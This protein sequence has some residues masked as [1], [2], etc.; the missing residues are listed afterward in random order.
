MANDPELRNKT[1]DGIPEFLA[2]ITRAWAQSSS[3]LVP[4]LAV[5]SA[6]LMGVP[7]LIISAGEGSVTEG[8][9]VS[10]DAYSALIEGAT[11]IAINNAMSA[12]SFDVLEDYAETTEIEAARF[13]P[14]AD[15]FARVAEIGEENLDRYE[16]FL[17]DYPILAEY[18]D[19]TFTDTT[20]RLD[21]LRDEFDDPDRLRDAADTLALLINTEASNG[22]VEGLAELVTDQGAD[23]DRLGTI[24]A[25]AERIP[26]EDI[27]DNIIDWVESNPFGIYGGDTVDSLLLLDDTTIDPAFWQTFAEMDDATFNQTRDDLSVVQELGFVATQRYAGVL[28]TLDELGIELRSNDADTIDDINELGLST[29]QEAIATSNELIEKGIDDPEALNAQLRRVGNFYDAGYLQSE[30]VNQ[31]LAEELA[32]ALDEHL[33]IKR[34]GNLFPLLI[35]D[36]AG[37]NIIGQVDNNQDLPVL[38]F[39]AGNVVFMFI[40]SELENT[41]VRAIP[42]IIAGLAVA[43][44]F[45]AGL[46]NIGAEGQIYMGALLVAWLGVALNLPAI[47]HL[48]VI[49]IVGIIGGFLYGAIPGALKAY[50]GAHEVITTIML[51]F[52]AI[53]F[54]DWIIKTDSSLGIGD[55]D[56]SLPRTRTIDVS[57]QMPTFDQL[58]PFLI[59]SVGFALFALLYWLRRNQPNAIMTPLL[60]GISIIIG[61]FVLQVLAVQ[62][63]LHLGFVLMLLAVWFTDWFLDR[64]TAGFEIRT[65][66]TNAN[67]ARYAGM[68]VNWNI[69]L[70]MALSGALAG[71]A[72]MIEI[73]AKEL[74]MQP[75]FIA[76][77]GFD[78]IAVALIARTNPRAMLWAGLLWGG[79]LS[80]SQLMQSRAGISIDLVKIV[81]ALIIMFIAADQIIRYVWR[82]PESE[83]EDKLVFSSG[84]G[85]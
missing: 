50:T 34:P 76:G 62:G 56:S 26:N 29:V 51:N 78:A 77:V 7:L 74:N 59:I 40:P 24:A 80:G 53:Q 25:L 63:D 44:G 72:G 83:D 71:Y 43:L 66:G 4:F 84:W 6:F 47:I 73:S 52:I 81:Q 27:F 13:K 38:Y 79:L 35:H 31:V 61:G 32:P 30:T 19:D 11:G 46:F 9:S 49:I 2:P 82:I 3:R 70:A 5:I 15:R 1:P 21:F 37:G 18:D 17:T 10:R 12:D 48:P 23:Q 57:A 65:V 16:T 42:F 75:G 68:N 22:S 8:I 45:K 41:L 54:V 20:E 69:L 60:F 67:A 28:Q 36:G 64:T 58:S 39:R 55:P 33:V 14:Q 85:G